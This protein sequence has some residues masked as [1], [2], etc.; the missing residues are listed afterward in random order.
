MAVCDCGSFGFYFVGTFFSQL[1]KYQFL[2]LHTV[3]LF[4]LEKNSMLAQ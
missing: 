2:S 4:S 3:T 1:R